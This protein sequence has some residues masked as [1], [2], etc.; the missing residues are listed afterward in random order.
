MRFIKDYLNIGLSRW[1]FLYLA[2]AAVI[3][4]LVGSVDALF[5]RV[6]LFLTA[7]RDSHAI[8]LLPFLALAGLLI[9][10][11]YQKMG[12]EALKGMALIFETGNR[13]REK[14]PKRLV[15]LGMVATWISHLFGASVGREGFAVQIGGTIGHFIGRKLSSEQAKKILLVTG[16]AA[17]FAGL[18][19]TPIAGTF[20]AIEI[21]ML[22]KIE[23]E[24]L[25]PALLASFVASS[26]SHFLGLEKFALTITATF[27]WTPTNLAKI[28]VISV[29]FGLV[30]R[31]FAMAVKYMKAEM[32]KRL[33]NPYVR[34]FTLGL[35]LG[36]L[37]MIVHFDRY[38]GLGTSLIA[39]AFHGGQIHG[40]D[41]L[42]KL[43]FTVLSLAAGYQGG[44]VTPLF[45]IGATLGTTLALLF[46]LPVPLIAAAGYCAIFGT[47]TNSYFAPIF[48]AAEVFGF[49]SIPYI[50][51][52]L[53]IAYLVNGN[54]SLYAQEKLTA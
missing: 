52:I 22:G 12:P 54:V 3:G 14:I 40:Y 27:A 1:T 18:F 48:I 13:N 33:P 5:G 15:P 38:A 30:G 44:E 21:L 9:V 39:Q 34:I 43:L 45:A 19:Q 50:L 32:T 46:G 7:F 37:L 16:M 23:Y 6:L 42:L 10:F 51:P 35:A 4:V 17:G 49:A 20:F 8:F 2:T 47:A 25:V 11:M 41:W 53:T 24:A 36:I 31:L 26:T 29:I 28:L